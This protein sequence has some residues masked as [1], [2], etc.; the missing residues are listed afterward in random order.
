MAFRKRTSREIEATKVRADS[1]RAVNPALE[2][3]KDKQNQP[4]SLAAL[5][6]ANAA[7]EALLTDYNG[8]LSELDAVGNRIKAGEKKANNLAARL[9]AGV[10][11]QFGK[12]SDEYEKAGGTKSDEIKR[13]PPVRK[14]KAGTT[15]TA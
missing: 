3:G 6:Q 7:V 13:K 10:G 15:P 9:L 1:L 12:D 5:D 2:F 11:T 8:R 4:V 14:P